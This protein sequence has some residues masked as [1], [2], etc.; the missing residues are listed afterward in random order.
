VSFANLGLYIPLHVKF[1]PIFLKTQFYFCTF[2]DLMR[3]WSSSDVT[4]YWI[5]TTG[6]YVSRSI[7]ASHAC[8][9]RWKKLEAAS[10]DSRLYYEV[11]S[12]IGL[13]LLIFL[14]PG[15]DDPLMTKMLIIIISIDW[16]ATG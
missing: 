15:F 8:F 3:T 14:P 11:N 7:F 13:I 6:S 2:F 4:F 1:Q 9:S 12:H 5:I 16:R 10:A